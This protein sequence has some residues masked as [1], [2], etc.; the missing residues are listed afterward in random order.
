MSPFLP[1]RRGDEDIRPNSQI[2]PLRS[3]IAEAGMLPIHLKSSWKVVPSQDE[4]VWVVGRY[5]A[6]RGSSL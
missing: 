3:D 6:T 1:V 5:F 2:K 4:K